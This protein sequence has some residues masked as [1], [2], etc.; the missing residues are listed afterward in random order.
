[1]NGKGFDRQQEDSV[2]IA[3]RLSE[4]SGLALSLWWR[5]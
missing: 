2:R 5:L 4:F 3:L 1:L